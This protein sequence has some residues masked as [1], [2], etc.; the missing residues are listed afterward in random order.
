ME[1][2]LANIA[3]SQALHWNNHKQIIKLNIKT[4]KHP[5]RR[6]ANQLAIYKRGRGNE[7]GNTEKQIQLVAGAE[8][9]SGSP[10]WE[11]NALT[12]RSRCPP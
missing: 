7:L 5:N 9:N 6:E 2:Y 11:S 10:G 12:T 4:V 1:V 8:S 3:S